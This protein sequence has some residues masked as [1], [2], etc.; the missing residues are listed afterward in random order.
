[1]WHHPEQQKVSH[2]CR[3]LQEQVQHKNLVPASPGIIRS[4]RYLQPEKV[5]LV[6]GVTG[7]LRLHLQMNKSLLKVQNTHLR[8]PPWW[9][10]VIGYKGLGIEVKSWQQFVSHN[11]DYSN[12]L[13]NKF[14]NINSK[15]HE[16]PILFLVFLEVQSSINWLQFFKF[17]SLF[18]SAKLINCVCIWWGFI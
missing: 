8:L 6:W 18:T 14:Y 15:L 16:S 3:N 12:I 4:T 5:K 11:W 2:R 13:C 7:H 17:F 9:Q 1:M 10:T